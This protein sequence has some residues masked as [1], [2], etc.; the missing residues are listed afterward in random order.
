MADVEGVVAGRVDI[1]YSRPDL[2]HTAIQHRRAVVPYERD[3]D[4]F[5]RTPAE[6]PA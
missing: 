3:M 6:M 4:A 2:R 5:L 1:H